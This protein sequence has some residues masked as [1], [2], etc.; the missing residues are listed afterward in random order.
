MSIQILIQNGAIERQLA[1]VLREIIDAKR[2]TDPASLR[3]CLEARARA[4]GLSVS[5]DR[6][7]RAFDLVGSNRHLFT[8]GQPPPRGP[9]GAPPSPEVPSRQEAK[10][11]LERYGIDVGRGSFRRRK[12][13]QLVPL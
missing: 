12:S 13:S 5:R 4:L 1:K 2:F 3:D 8:T 9:C 7:E 10:A 6:I 11:T